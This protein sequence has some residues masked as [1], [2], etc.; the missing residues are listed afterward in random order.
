MEITMVLD[1]YRMAKD[2][3]L[4]A[5][6]WRQQGVLFIKEN[7][8]DEKALKENVTDA[9]LMLYIKSYC[10]ENN[11]VNINKVCLEKQDIATFMDTV[12]NKNYSSSRYKLNH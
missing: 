5:L 12:N 9:T 7:N 1:V 3:K 6:I 8:E 10:S 4:T 11:A 2:G